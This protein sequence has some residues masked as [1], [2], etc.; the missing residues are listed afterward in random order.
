MSPNEELPATDSPGDR[1]RWSVARRRRLGATGRAAA[2]GST[3]ADAP[4]T[5]G[6]SAGA[7]GNPDAEIGRKKPRQA[8][9]DATCRTLSRGRTG[10]SPAESLEGSE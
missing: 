5:M 3:R 4:G 1:S 6:A 2:G 10:D 9:R 7:S 8:A